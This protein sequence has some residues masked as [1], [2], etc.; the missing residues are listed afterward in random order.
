MAPLYAPL[1][2]AL[3]QKYEELGLGADALRAYEQ[4]IALVPA[5]PHAHFYFTDAGWTIGWSLALVARTLQRMSALAPTEEQKLEYF[6][7]SIDWQER[8]LRRSRYMIEWAGGQRRAARLPASEEE[9]DN[10]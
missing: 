8:A 10:E 5:R 1:W 7:R 9:T 3:G 6:S 4:Y 2:L